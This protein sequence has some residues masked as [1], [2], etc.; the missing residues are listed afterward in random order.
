MPVS[1]LQMAYPGPV[2]SRLVAGLWRISDWGRNAADNLRFVETCLDLGITTFDHAD[3]YG[4]YESQRVFGEA[5]AGNPGLREQ[6]LLV[7]KC[8]IKLVSRHFPAHRIGHYDTSK[9]H[10]IQSVEQS[11]SE[12]RTDRVDVLLIHRPDLLMDADEVAEAFLALKAAGKVL[13]FGVSNFSPSQFDLLADRLPFPLV[14]NQVECSVLQFDVMH[15]GT[16]DHCQRIRM[17]PMAWSPLGGGDLFHAHTDQ[18]VRLR[19]TLHEIGRACGGASLDQVAL[20]WLLRH[21]ARIVP[22]LGTGNLDRIRSAIAAEAITLSTQQ[23][24]QI[25][26]ASQGHDVP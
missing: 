5:M 7:T 21:P 3:I 19:Q 24:Y 11:L 10:I 26:R 15:D 16:L 9:A 17:A 23:W 8:N 2:F 4:E 14:T 25:W 6:M 20:A 18:A 13:H 22:V 12:L 1:T